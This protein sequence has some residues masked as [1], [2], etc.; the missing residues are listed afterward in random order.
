MSVLLICL[1]S[2]IVI[3][4][5]C[6][7]VD[8]NKSRFKHL[9]VKA[10]VWRTQNWYISWKI[11]VTQNG[12]SSQV[13]WKQFACQFIMPDIKKN[14]QY[15]FKLPITIYAIYTQ[16]FRIHHNMLGYLYDIQ[17]K[18]RKKA[19]N[20]KKKRYLRKCVLCL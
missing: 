9:T 16:P 17:Q 4:F 2:L 5:R 1:L 7:R 13:V 3:M 20:T 15:T 18:K 19:K 6:Y 8:N 11:P 12:I 14:T 10:I